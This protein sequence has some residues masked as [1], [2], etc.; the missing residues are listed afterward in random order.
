MS[1]C[2]KHLAFIPVGTCAYPL[3]FTDQTEARG[4]PMATQELSSCKSRFPN[5]FFFFWW[6]WGLNSGLCSCKAGI[7]PLEPLL[8]SILL[9]LFWRLGLMNYLPTLALNCNPPDLCPNLLQLQV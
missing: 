8:Q 2:Y 1:A 6:D 9:W 5:F 3:V 7:L 4:L